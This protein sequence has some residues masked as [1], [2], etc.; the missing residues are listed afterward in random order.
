MEFEILV[1]TEIGA[2]E[3]LIY[4]LIVTPVIDE[5][6]DVTFQKM[7]QLKYHLGLLSK[8]F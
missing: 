8:L 5:L 3:I 2:D 1:F 6:D 7:L 4:M